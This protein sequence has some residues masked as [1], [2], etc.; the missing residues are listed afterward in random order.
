MTQGFRMSFDHN[1][2]RVTFSFN[3]NFNVFVNGNSQGV[4]VDNWVSEEAEFSQESFLDSSESSESSR[5]EFSQFLDQ[6]SEEE[7]SSSESISEGMNKFDARKAFQEVKQL[8]E[9]RELN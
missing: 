5:E 8:L 4:F 2:N 6:D 1:S 9:R 7:N 3:S